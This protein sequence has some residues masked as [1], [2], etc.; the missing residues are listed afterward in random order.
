MV[1][2]LASESGG[3]C[4]YT[5]PNEVVRTDNGVTIVGFTD[6]PSRLPTQVHRWP[7]RGG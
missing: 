4:E 2:D 7:C 1:V 5:V 3:N 6:L